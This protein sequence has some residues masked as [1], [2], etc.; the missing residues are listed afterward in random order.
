MKATVL[1]TTMVICFVGCSAIDSSSSFSNAGNRTVRKGDSLSHAWQGV[2]IDLT[3]RPII[4]ELTAVDLIF[5]S[6]ITNS[7]QKS[8]FETHAEYESRLRKTHPGDQTYFLELDSELVD[9][10][11][12]ADSLML[13]VAARRSFATIMRLEERN[14]NS[15]EARCLTV[16]GKRWDTKGVRQLSIM[17]FEQLP[18]LI[19]PK[20]EGKGFDCVG[21]SFPIARDDARQLVER[22]EVTLVLPIKIGDLRLAAYEKLTR[23]AELPVTLMGA[24]VI[25]SKQRT[26]LASLIARE[27]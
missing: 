27:L 21:L 2:K 22:R 11:Y 7:L 16:A 17:N 23:N 9:C 26:V 3:G 6:V 10:A 18:A 13:T 14:S 5:A 1:L 24:I 4:E 15:W 8:Q 25:T 20:L 12:D 19:R